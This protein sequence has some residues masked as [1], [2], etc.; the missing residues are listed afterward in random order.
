M[1][2][3]ASTVHTQELKLKVSEFGQ[4]LDNTY[5]NIDDVV[6]YNNDDYGCNRHAKIK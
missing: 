1:P 5:N 2:A 6:D 3:T 4:N